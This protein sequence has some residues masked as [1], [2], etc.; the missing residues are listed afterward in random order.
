MR[1][2][3]GVDV[4]SRLPRSINVDKLDNMNEVTLGILAVIC[5]SLVILGVVFPIYE[6]GGIAWI[7][8]WEEP[9]G[10]LTIVSTRA[11]VT[12]LAVATTTARIAAATS[13]TTATIA[14]TTT[15]HLLDVI[16]SLDEF[17]R[18]AKH[19]AGS[20]KVA[21]HRFDVAGGGSISQVDFTRV[22]VAFMN[23]SKE[24]AVT[25]FQA[26]DAEGDG[27]ITP[28][29][30]DVNVEWFRR[31]LTVIGSPEA[32]FKNMD[33]DKDGKLSEHEIVS[34]GKMLTPRISAAMMRSLMH[35]LDQDRDGVISIYEFSLHS[36]KHPLTVEEFQQYSHVAAI[37]QGRSDLSFD[38]PVDVTLHPL[39]AF[40]GKISNCLA[41]AIESVANCS[42]HVQDSTVVRTSTERA[43][44]ITRTI[45]ID[46]EVDSPDGAHFQSTMRRCAAKK[47][48][49]LVALQSPGAT[50]SIWTELTAQYYGKEAVGLVRGNS[51][52]QRVGHRW[53]T[54]ITDDCVDPLPFTDSEEQR[55]SRNLRDGGSQSA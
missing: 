23:V 14:I 27:K 43:G 19:W 16:D 49:K 51:L 45:R 50:I 39:G 47:L 15:F 52:K 55:V 6:V 24:I 32:I 44:N 54:P 30:C 12:S 20:M 4:G 46:W 31:K 33:F 10:N 48:E 35:D 26:F 34:I 42:A 9:V 8:S 29:V 2:A 1:E 28:E 25:V 53:G 40:L 38:A 17:R 22:A 36:V 21:C 5:A 37:I 18:K 11:P 41:D 13:T 3:W 7:R